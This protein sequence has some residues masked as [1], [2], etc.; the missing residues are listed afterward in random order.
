VRDKIPPTR[1]TGLSFS[2][3]S[4]TRHRYRSG[5]TLVTAR[6]NAS[7]LLTHGAAAGLFL[8]YFTITTTRALFSPDDLFALIEGFWRLGGF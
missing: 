5:T 6:P 3:N 2:R 4:H 1:S 8:L 7:P